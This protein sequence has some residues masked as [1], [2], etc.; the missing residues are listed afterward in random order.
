MRIV[1]LAN[2]YSEH[3]GGLRTTLKALAYHYRQQ[4]HEVVRVVPGPEHLVTDDGTAEVIHLPSMAVGSTGYRAIIP[5]GNVDRLLV[6]LRPETVELSDKTTLVAAARRCRARGARVLLLSHERLDAILR[7]RVPGWVPLTA[8]TNS[9]NRRLMAS[10]DDVVCASSF[11]AAEWVRVGAPHVH[12]VPFG[13]DLETFRPESAVGRSGHGIT[14]LALVS[15]LSTEKSAG[16]AIET[17]RCLVERGQDCLL[18]IAGD[19]PEMQRLQHLA[20]GLPVVFLGH[21]GSRA[22][23]V[24]LLQRSHVALA[25]CSI[26][27]FGLAAL[28]AM[29]CGTPVVAAAAGALPELLAS[30]AGVAVRPTPE[31]FAAAIVSFRRVDPRLT[32]LLARAHAEQYSWHNTAEAF[33]RIHSG[34]A[35]A[36]NRASMSTVG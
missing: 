36:I 35:L 32:A 33:L 22:A 31:A 28:E 17:V 9:W 26:E 34:S 10:V 29:A 23:V 1:Q 20:A 16:L 27:T 25:P 18:R 7:P 5:G 14:E 24:T 21:L 8:T 15:R 6:N 13:V 3:S 2:F 19:G 30:G 4:G 12:R 11:A